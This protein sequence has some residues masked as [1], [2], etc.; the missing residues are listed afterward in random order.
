M[1]SHLRRAEGSA[2]GERS[3]RERAHLGR[4]LGSLSRQ[5]SQ[6]ARGLA[7]HRL[8]TR[9]EQALAEMR[10]VQDRR[11]WPRRCGQCLL[12]QVHTAHCCVLMAR[13]QV[14]ACD[15]H[16]LIPSAWYK[17]AAA[18]LLLLSPTEGPG[19]TPC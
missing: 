6:E 13:Q 10:M 16:R 3:G 1:D 15:M 17:A 12:M 19:L 14:Q 9:A 2:R 18:A 8:P 7:A 11:E 4:L 5:V